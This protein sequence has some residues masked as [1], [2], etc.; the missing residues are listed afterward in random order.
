LLKASST[1]FGKR[2]PSMRVMFVSG[3][4]DR[5]TRNFAEVTHIA[6]EHCETLFDGG[7]ANHEIVER[8]HVPSRRFL[9]LNLA[10]KPR[11]VCRK[12]VDRDQP[13]SSSMYSRRRWPTFGVVAR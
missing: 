5:E 4:E 13:Q 1:M 12:R 8:Q 10:N 7:S 11:G 3:R 6:S 2:C 9:A